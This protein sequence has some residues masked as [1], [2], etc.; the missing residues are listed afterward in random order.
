LDACVGR[1]REALRES[2]QDQDT[3]FIF[4]SDH[5]DMLGSQGHARKQRPWDESIRVPFLLRFPSRFG[6]APR[7]CDALIDAPDIMPTLLGLCGMEIPQSVEGLDYSGYL[8]GGQD[9]SE[10]A[11]LITCYHTFGEWTG[12]RASPAGTSAHVYRG[13]RTRRHTYVR[14]LDG[15]WL[16]YDNE[17]DP[18]QMRNLAGLTQYAEIQDQLDARLT[19]KLASLGDAFLP[20]R[21]YVRK[22]GY[23]VD[24]TGTVPSYKNKR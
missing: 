10:G 11:A 17:A 21:E 24:D 23:P 12:E 9:P 2:G 5:G 14:S 19:E 15:P 20:G 6:D 4:T 22:W 3:L 18:F 7:T 1:L 8:Q 13:L 16:F